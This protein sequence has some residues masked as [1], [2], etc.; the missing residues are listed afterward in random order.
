MTL[1]NTFA[2]FNM[3]LVYHGRAWFKLRPTTRIPNHRLS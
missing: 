3:V 1:F 2:I